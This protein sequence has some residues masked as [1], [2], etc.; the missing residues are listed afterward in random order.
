MLHFFGG[1]Y[2]GLTNTADKVGVEKK[3]FSGHNDE[4]RK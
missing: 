4:E 1:L 2:N 3:V